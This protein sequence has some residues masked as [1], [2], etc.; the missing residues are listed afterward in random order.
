MLT[1]AIADTASSV[2]LSS[3]AFQ[4]LYGDGAAKTNEK[5]NTKNRSGIHD[6]PH[7]LGPKGTI[8]YCAAMPIK[9]N[10]KKNN[11]K[12]AIDDCLLR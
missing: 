12:G 9:N 10:T 11:P 5:S 6:I 2:S 8:Q 3:F 7:I 1:A 4:P